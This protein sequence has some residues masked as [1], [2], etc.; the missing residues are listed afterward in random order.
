[1]TS[2]V[3]HATLITDEGCLVYEN[4]GITRLLNHI[5]NAERR[6]SDRFRKSVVAMTD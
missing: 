5:G 2:N 4:Y 1:M 3:T 6:L